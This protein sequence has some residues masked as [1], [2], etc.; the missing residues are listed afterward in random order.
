M[1]KVL[2]ESFPPCNQPLNKTV[3]VNRG[4]NATFRVSF[5]EGSNV[6]SHWG[7][8]FAW[9]NAEGKELCRSSSI[10][11]KECVS[12][13]YE[14]FRMVIGRKQSGS[15][16]YSFITFSF[17]IYISKSEYNHSGIYFVQSN[18]TS[19]CTVLRVAV[20][21][22]DTRPLCSAILDKVPEHI[23]LSCKWAMREPEDM[24]ELIAGNQTL[25]R[26]GNDELVPGTVTSS[27]T[28]M[29]VSSVIALRDAFDENRTPD[30][31]VV[32]NIQ[33][34]FIN[35][36]RL[37]VFMSPKIN[38]I[39]EQ[40][41]HFFFTCCA[42]NETYPKLWWYTENTTIAATDTQD[43]RFK[44]HVRTSSHGSPR[45]GGGDTKTS[46]II[47]CGREEKD[48]LKLFG[49]GKII[50]NLRYRE[51]V[52]LSGRI[53]RGRKLLPVNN[54]EA[55]CTD[56]FNITIA[57]I[58]LESEGTTQTT[59]VIT[60]AESD[61]T[62]PPKVTNLVDVNSFEAW[63]SVIVTFVISLLF[64]FALCAIK[65]YDIFS[66]RKVSRGTQNQIRNN[67]RAID[68][69]GNMYEEN[70]LEMNISS[71]E[72]NRISDRNGTSL[73][74]YETTE[75]EPYNT[76]QLDKGNRIEEKHMCPLR[77]TSAL[78][79]ANLTPTTGQ[80]SPIGAL[81]HGAK[82][83]FM[84]KAPRGIECSHEDDSATYQDLSKNDLPMNTT[85]NSFHIASGD[86]NYAGCD[87]QFWASLT[88]T[89]D[90]AHIPITQPVIGAH[91]V[92]PKYPDCL[93][94]VPDKPPK[95]KTNMD[96]STASSC[97][98]GCFT[99][100]SPNTVD[101]ALA[102]ATTSDYDSLRRPCIER[103]LK[104]YEDLSK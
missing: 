20:I 89:E 87:F 24:V 67:P 8:V 17:E 71:M 68:I 45:Q 59:G 41:G 58:S 102:T 47:I 91:C 40:G 53:E 84:T 7:A 33:L 94:A 38:K 70:T 25:Q 16:L 11:Y 74:V 48:V 15:S 5:T 18:Y 76:S 34:N 31:C 22:R 93:Y 3:R 9:L 96:I 95:S 29:V 30:V 72:L 101:S 65:C 57:V 64:N 62:S 82:D 46:V 43:H 81:H 4:E 104:L 23:E 60:I 27:N 28:A 52:L 49:M 100:L 92:S 44:I 32:S 51:G 2:V 69:V 80:T 50:L 61:R 79:C 6:G 86:A 99:S 54:S 35:L 97:F 14:S 66:S 36:C 10:G 103:H 90:F 19:F 26:I 37:S 88:D 56:I 73:H 12:D 98:S 21:V 85:H 78:D 63:I 55:K 1:R 13:R 42:D 75:P 83:N 39:Y 77:Y